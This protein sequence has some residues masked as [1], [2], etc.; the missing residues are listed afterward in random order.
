MKNTRQQKVLQK[1]AFLAKK[2]ARDQKFSD[3]GSLAFNK[4]D[5]IPKFPRPTFE[6]FIDI[7]DDSY[8]DLDVEDILKVSRFIQSQM[9]EEEKALKAE[10]IKSEAEEIRWMYEEECCDGDPYVYIR[11]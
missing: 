3:L 7:N 1:K 4:L 2:K 6:N 10:R 9:N 5:K 8:Y 11:I